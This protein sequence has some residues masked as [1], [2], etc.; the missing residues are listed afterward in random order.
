M[1]GRIRS[2][3]VEHVCAAGPTTRPEWATAEGRRAAACHL[4][5]PYAML[6]WVGQEVSETRRRHINIPKNALIIL[7]FARV[8][9]RDGRAVG[10]SAGFGGFVG[11]TVFVSYSRRDE[12][13][14]Q[15]LLSAFRHAQEEVL[16][17]RELP[18]G[19]LW[20]QKI[21]EQIRRCDVFVFALSQN[22]LDSKPCM[23]ELQ[24]A[25]ALS[26]PVLPVL[27]GRVIAERTSPFAAT[28]YIDY[29][30]PNADSGSQLISNLHRYAAN[31]QPLSDPLPPEPPM[32][33]LYL[34]RLQKD[35]TGP[36]EIPPPEQLQMLVEL[37]SRLNEE[38]GD[39]SA[40][41]DIARLL[42]KLRD[43]TDAAPA[44]RAEVDK[45][46]DELDLK[47]PYARRVS[48]T[49]LLGGVALLVA[50]VVAVVV[51]FV[52]VSGRDDARAIPT[53]K[54]ATALLTDK[55]IDGVIGTS[56][57]KG[58]EIA[59]KTY[60]TNL[61]GSVRP[62]DCNGALYNVGYRESRNQAL[63]S[64]ATGLFV[65]QSAIGFPSPA[66]ASAFVLDSA[67]RWKTCSD[68]PVEVIEPDGSRSVWTFT[69]LD[70]KGSQIIQ[71]MTLQREQEAYVCQKEL[72]AESS[73]VIE[74]Q[75]CGDH[76][77]DE[78]VSLAEKMAA[79][80]DE[81]TRQV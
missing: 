57:M 36:Q 42:W 20:W 34:M 15:R 45:M 40:R 39:A 59:D 50:V 77:N 10:G 81:L 73:V 22:S 35:I 78:A 55:E 28:H 18:G 16:Y 76:S 80:V 11:M 75:V 56:D 69:P 44:T 67:D 46:L 26:K 74:M 19:E 71:A 31:R 7:A 13:L 41:A 58:G 47:R 52:M 51:G 72:R 68:Q 70:V 8:R 29:R 54:L 49:W 64:D 62:P 32:P 1:K 63:K 17:D 6:V 9:I 21:L 37:K 48:R 33:F 14:V 53:E 30:N 79:K 66:R 2:T 3:Y 12:K 43:R 38:A 61:K 4:G 65:N 24:Y 27:V 25:E 23:A 5:C 60:A